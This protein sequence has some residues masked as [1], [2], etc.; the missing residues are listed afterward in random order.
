MQIAQEGYIITGESPDIFAGYSLPALTELWIENR[1]QVDMMEATKIN[2]LI[3]L[4]WRG[5]A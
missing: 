1:L 2:L 5:Q 4:S 3:W